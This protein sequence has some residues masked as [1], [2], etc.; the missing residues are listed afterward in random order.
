MAVQL[1][2]T[3][4]YVREQQASAA[5]LAQILGLPEPTRFG[6]F[7]VVQTGV[8]SMDFRSADSD[9]IR[10][11]HYAFLVTEAEFDEIFRRIKAQNLPYW[12]DPH[13]EQPN[14]INHRDKG[15]GVYFDDPDGH[16]L[17]ILTRPYGSNGW[18]N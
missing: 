3:I 14:E 16:N 6:P 8:T 1:N 9:D 18:T 2:H 11:Q 4:I 7:S 5:F 12:A 13:H 15:R 17:E 10:P